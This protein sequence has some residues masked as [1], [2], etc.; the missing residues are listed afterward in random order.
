MEYKTLHGKKASELS[1]TQ[2]IKVANM[3]NLIK[4]KKNRDHAPKN[5]VLK[6]RSVFN[7]KI[8]HILYTKGETAY[9]TLS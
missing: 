5:P 1:I 3:I 7:S 4:G 8:Q 2:G 9:S 6:A